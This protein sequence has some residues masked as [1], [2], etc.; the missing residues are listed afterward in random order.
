MVLQRMIAFLQAAAHTWMLTA[1]RDARGTNTVETV[2]I[3]AGVI[4]IVGIVIAAITAYVNANV[5]R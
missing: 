3:I 4:V 5:P 1:R 2:L